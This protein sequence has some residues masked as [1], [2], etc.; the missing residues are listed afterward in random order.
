VPIDAGRMG[1]TLQ[2]RMSPDS[3]SPG[4]LGPNVLYGRSEK[5][6]ETDATERV[7]TAFAEAKIQPPAVLHG[8]C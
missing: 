6:S 1:E 5:T 7:L 8:S 4:P 3:G 2:T